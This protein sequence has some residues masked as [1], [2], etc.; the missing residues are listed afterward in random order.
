MKMSLV[1]RVFLSWIFSLIFLIMLV[2][3][4]EGMVHW[5]WFVIFLPVWTMDAALVLLLLVKLA[6]RCRAEAE[7]GGRRGP[8]AAAA[9]AR[10]LS[11]LA[12]VALKATFCLCLCSRLE[13]LMDAWLSVVCV[14]LWVLLG[15]SLLELGRRVFRSDRD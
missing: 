1:Q 15:G 6:A 4:L 10:R 9:V 13:E 3:K 14:P 7:A 12:A 11:C 8:A 2:L 5:N